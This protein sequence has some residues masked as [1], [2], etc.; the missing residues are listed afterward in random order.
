MVTA[1]MLKKELLITLRDMEKKRSKEREKREKVEKKR[2]L[3]LLSYY[4]T[5]FKTKKQ[6]TFGKEAI[7][8]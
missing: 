8:F 3:I 1:L 5:Q 7:I 2:K 6:G 4:H